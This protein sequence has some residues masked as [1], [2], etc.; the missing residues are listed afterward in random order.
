MR[1]IEELKTSLKWTVFHAR[2]DWRRYRRGWFGSWPGRWRNSARR[3]M[4][5]ARQLKTQIDAL[6]SYENKKKQKNLN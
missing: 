5:E 2:Q 6:I 4:V 1:T 3:R